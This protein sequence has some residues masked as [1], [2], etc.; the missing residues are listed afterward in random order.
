[1]RTLLLAGTSLLALSASLA[2]AAAAP[3]TFGYT[4]S[5]QTF[6][7]PAAGSYDILASGAQGSSALGNAGGL[8]AEIGGD[9]A[10]NAGETLTIDVGGVGGNGVGSG[11]GGVAGGGGGTFVVAPG[12][13]PLVIVGA[14]GGAGYL[15]A[16]GAGG[17]TGTAGSSGT[18]GGGA[19]GTGG[20]GGS[21]GTGAGGGG[22]GGGYP[23]LQGGSSGRA[24]FRICSLRVTQVR[25]RRRPV[26][27]GQ[28]LSRCPLGRRSA[29]PDQARWG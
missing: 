1:M 23:G 20:G 17:Q 9:F 26:K 14:G 7:A 29:S 24:W 22:G 6:T 18:N 2:T 16:A 19:G 21:A 27:A 28:R 12:S 4:G 10:L 11:V 5:V 8:G 3:I 25:G 13:V 15:A